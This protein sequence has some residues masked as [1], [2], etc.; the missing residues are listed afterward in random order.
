MKKIFKVGQVINPLK[1]KVITG[2]FPKYRQVSLMYPSRLNA[3]ALDSSKVAITDNG[4]YSPGEIV[5]SIS[6]FK[7]V[8]ATLRNDDQIIIKT[9]IKRK[10][11]IKHAILLMFSALDVKVGIDLE[12]ESNDMKH[13]GLG[14]SGGIIAATACVINEL[15]GNQIKEFELIKYLAQNHGEEIDDNVNNLQHVQ[16]IGGAASA[17]LIRAGMIIISGQSVP[18]GSYKIDALVNKVVIG[19][20]EDFVPPDAKVLMELEIANMDKFISTGNKFG[21]K[22]AYR[23]IHETMPNMKEGNLYEA[24]KLIFDYRFNYG[25]IDNCSFVYPGIINIAKNIRFLFEEKKL[26]TLALS[27]VGPAFFA[28]TDDVEEC[29]SVFQ[30]NGLKTYVTTINN[31]GYE[32]VHKVLYETI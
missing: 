31:D 24:S 10:Q 27:S 13:C 29:E 30:K 17:G 22:I 2:L 23:L 14:S 21:E 19:V 3:M 18:I 9:D 26:K 5:F 32:I 1:N 15:Y 6:I 28:I 12:F 7:K 20:P 11:L 16:C 8:T 25:S 4:V